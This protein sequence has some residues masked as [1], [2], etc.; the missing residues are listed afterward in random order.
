MMNNEHSAASGSCRPT[1]WRVGAQAMA[2]SCLLAA[3]TALAQ[4]SAPAKAPN[5]DWSPLACSAD[6]RVVVAAAS[7]L[8]RWY[9]PSLVYVSTNGGSGWAPAPLPACVWASVACSADGSCLAAAVFRGAMSQGDGGPVYVSTNAGQTWAESSAP[10]L[11]WTALAFAGDGTRLLAAGN[12]PFA[13][14]VVYASTDLGRAWSLS[15]RDLQPLVQ[16]ASS[17][18]GTRLVATGGFLGGAFVST[19]TNSGAAWTATTIEADCVAISVD[20]MRMVAV[21]ST[22]V[23]ASEDSGASWAQTWDGTLHIPSSL[24]SLVSVAMSADGARLVGVDSSALLYASSDLG[25]NWLRSW[26]PAEHLQAICGSRDGTRLVTAAAGGGIYLSTNS[27]SGWHNESAPQVLGQ[28]ASAP[29]A[30]WRAIACSADGTNLVACESPVA[31]LNSGQ[32][33][34]SHNRGKDWTLTSAPPDRWTALASSANGSKLVAVAGDT[35]GWFNVTF[36]SGSIIS[37]ADF[38]QSWTQTSA[39]LAPWSSVACS[40]NGD[41]VLAATWDGAVYFSSDSAATWTLT[42]APSNWWAAVTISADGARLAAAPCNGPIYISTNAGRAWTTAGLT[43]PPEW[44]AWSTNLSTFSHYWWYALAMS[45][46]GSK[47]AVGGPYSMFISSDGGATWWQGAVPW[48]PRSIALSADGTSLAVASPVLSLSSDS[49]ATWT[50]A[51]FTNYVSRAAISADGT[52]LAGLASSSGAR[53][54][55]DNGGI[56]VAQTFPFA[57]APQLI[58]VP[59]WTVTQ[60]N[61]ATSSNAC[62]TLTWQLA[63]TGYALQASSDLDPAG[64]ADVNWGTQGLVSLDMNHDAD[65]QAVFSCLGPQRFFRLKKE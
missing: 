43:N 31:A 13:N 65:N 6:A 42:S 14:G 46:D 36:Y 41:R 18:D 17:S 20:G 52:K 38:G 51:A 28:P 5:L 48:G 15:S 1:I 23:W 33:Y 63:Q 27:A 19:S 62:V 8:S 25:S 53:D 11:Q 55:D 40:T 61:G 29:A 24:V 9:I 59:S 35:F 44:T 56:F 16:I 58:V 7:G 3:E 34:V 49:G 21:D 2:I 37:S 32:I 45:A 47:L 12:D 57:P 54:V 10:V 60:T 4:S 39:P 26:G 22:A 50:E 30:N 64:W